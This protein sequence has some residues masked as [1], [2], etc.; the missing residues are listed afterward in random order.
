MKTE[1]EMQVRCKLKRL[2]LFL[3]KCVLT[4]VKADLEMCGLKLNGNE[5]LA[6]EVASASKG[7]LYL[8]ARAKCYL[9]TNHIPNLVIRKCKKQK[10]KV[11]I[12]DFKQFGLL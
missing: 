12:S 9:S 7:G 5:V 6:Q 4:D 10:T 3:F 8:T 1:T 2:K 11:G